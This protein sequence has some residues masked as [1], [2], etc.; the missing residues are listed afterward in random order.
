MD[1][2]LLHVNLF[3]YNLSASATEKKNN[4]DGKDTLWI[5]IYFV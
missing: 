3:G 2:H 4:E 1:C 5:A